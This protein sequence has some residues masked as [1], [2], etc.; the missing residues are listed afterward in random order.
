MTT[1]VASKTAASLPTEADLTS[2]AQQTL[3][4]ARAQGASSAEVS[5]SVGVGLSV[6]VRQSEV[7]T[8]E[9]QRDRSLTVAVYF[10]HRQGMA[11]SADFSP[12]SIKATVA[13]AC[14]IARYT[15]E[16]PCQGLADPEQLAT[17]FPDL[18]LYHPWD[19]DAEGA[20][21]R[22]MACE[23]AALGLDD[24]ITNSD[25]ASVSS[26]RG[27]QVYANSHGFIGT[28]RST[29]HSMSCVVI[30]GE[31][32]GMQRDYWYTSG[33]AP[34]LLESAEAVGRRA[35]ERTLMRLGSRRLGTRSSP[36][37]YAPSVAQGLLGHF[38]AAVRGG[39]LYRKSSFLLDQLGKP[40]F[41]AHI[42]LRELPHLPRAMG[43]TAFDNEGVATR[44]RLLV[45][46]GVLQ[47]YVLDSYSA[48][49]LKMTTTGNAGGV[50]NLSI[51][52]GKLDQAGLMKE[53]GTGLMVTELMGA[54]ANT[55]TG[56]Y[57]RGASGF[58]IENGEIAYPVQEI[59]VAGN[60]REV[61]KGLS[62]V[63]N[64]LDHRGN[65]ITGSLLIDNMTIAGE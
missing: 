21:E 61:Y 15:S 22:A 32:D 38:V 42:T 63:G 17:E 45:D 19:L 11:S 40:V 41:P 29:R 8:L 5:V 33:R 56:D 31:R 25:G 54:G 6:N 7:D 30:A 13:A 44:D 12:D 39:A 62:A 34:E 20:I 4:Q 57:S 14:S 36:V 51:T 50:H 1:A 26:Q 47:G 65:I 9:H 23:A 52:P 53:M 3:D 16:D 64:D 43:S 2:L 60:M 18:D 59:T 24:R 46:Q 28:R 10:G 55:T 37:L 49:K 35:A 48:R 27:L 58:W